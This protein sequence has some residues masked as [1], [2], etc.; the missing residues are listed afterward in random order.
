[1]HML[2]TSKMSKFVGLTVLLPKRLNA[3][4]FMP[5]IH[6]ESTES[7]AWNKEIDLF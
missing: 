7:G 5:G 3:P 6:A 4:I 1:M 2:V